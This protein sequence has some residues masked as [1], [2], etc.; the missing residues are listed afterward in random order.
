MW[1]FEFIVVSSVIPVNLGIGA[2]AAVG[3]FGA[4]A[5]EENISEH[6]AGARH[7]IDR[8]VNPRRTAATPLHKR[9][10]ACRSNNSPTSRR[11]SARSAS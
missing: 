9:P 5:W 6:L 11:S 10:T 2:P 7:N 3:H 8:H 1:T 4:A